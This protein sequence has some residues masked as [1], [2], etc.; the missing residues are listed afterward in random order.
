M[1]L[2]IEFRGGSPNANPLPPPLPTYPSVPISPQMITLFEVLLL[3]LQVCKETE[4]NLA[5]ILET[6]GLPETQSVALEQCQAL[7]WS[8][9]N[10]VPF[11]QNL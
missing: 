11:S 5:L 10:N 6:E 2:S 1:L 7:V 4:V 3:F 9:F 8:L